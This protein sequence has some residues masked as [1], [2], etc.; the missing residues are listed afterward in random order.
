M[1][2]FIMGV[3]ILSTL[4]AC[5]S[6]PSLQKYLVEK[7]SSSEFVSASLS[8]DLLIQNLDSLSLEEK[9]SV[10][11]I[12]KI[13]VLAFLKEKGEST[14]E[15]E[16]TLLRSILNQTEYKSL[17]NFNGADRE[18]KFLYSGYKEDIKEI[19]FFGYDVKVGMLLLR[20]RGS[21]IEPND[22][23]KISQMGDQLNLGAISSFG[24][25]IERSTQ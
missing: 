25:L 10:Q 17:I 16:R 12:E 23:F 14:L 2:S 21:D 20:M 7:E 1:K 24:D 4:L 5:N 3:V 19:I 11:K 13:N 8:M 22:I 15:V 18:A 6:K 9:E